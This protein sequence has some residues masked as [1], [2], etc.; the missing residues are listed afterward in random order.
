MMKNREDRECN[1]RA[2]ERENA[3]GAIDRDFTHSNGSSFYRAREYSR[4]VSA[5]VPKVHTTHG[6]RMRDACV[7]PDAEEAQPL[8]AGGLP[9]GRRPRCSLLLLELAAIVGSFRADS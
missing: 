3:R 4:D 1:A 8:S 9:R 7:T 2:T 6:I 5:S